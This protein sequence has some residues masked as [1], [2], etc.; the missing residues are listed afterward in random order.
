VDVTIRPHDVSHYKGF[1]DRQ[2][3]SQLRDTKHSELLSHLF[4]KLKSTK[5]V[6]GESLFQNT[7][8]AFGSN[9]STGHFLDRCPVVIAGNTNNLKH[10]SHLCMPKGTPLCNLWLTLLRAGGVKA[11]SFGDSNGIIEGLVA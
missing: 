5:D 6:N 4:D 2:A 7:S 9:I 1:E 11:K 3:I 8:V 10:G